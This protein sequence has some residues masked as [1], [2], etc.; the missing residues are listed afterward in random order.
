MSGTGKDGTI[1]A[2]CGACC[3][4]KQG[5]AFGNKGQGWVA[6]ESDGLLLS[7]ILACTLSSG[8]E[9]KFLRMRVAKHRVMTSKSV[10]MSPQRPWKAR[11]REAIVII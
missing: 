2:C 8:K 1:I 9:G 4:L 5:R 6:R 7:S 11:K 10:T 3:R